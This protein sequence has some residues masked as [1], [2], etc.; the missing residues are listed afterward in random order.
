M[1]DPK[2]KWRG[3]D[4]AQDLLT[5]TVIVALWLNPPLV[6]VTV[7][8]NVPLLVVEGT[9]TVSVDVPEP[10][11]AEGVAVA[12]N[13]PPDTLV[14]RLT[15]PVNPFRYVIVIFE[16]PDEQLL[17]LMLL[18]DAEIEKFGVVTVHVTVVLW[19]SEPLLPV[20]V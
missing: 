2:K 18:G 1:S 3:I 7:T 5:L 9:L 19:L 13:P 16:V 20:T 14:D 12:V 10:V 4:Y 15:V 8:V 17:T 6:P 11:N